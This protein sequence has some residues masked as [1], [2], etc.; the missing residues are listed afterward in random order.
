MVTKMKFLEGAKVLKHM[1]DR[2][3]TANAYPYK[4]IQGAFLEYKLDEDH[5][6]LY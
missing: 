3:P 5:N 2:V 4:K 6:F 1:F